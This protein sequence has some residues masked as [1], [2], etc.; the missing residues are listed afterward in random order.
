M[1]SAGGALALPKCKGTNSSAWTNCYGTYNGPKFSYEGEY[2][3]G[4]AHGKGI[5]IWESGEKYVGDF[6]NDDRNG[7]GTFTWPDGQ[8][9]V[10]EYKNEKTNGQGIRTW[11][12]GDKYVGQEQN[13]RKNGQGIF[14]YANGK[15]DEGIWKD[16]KFQYAQKTS[17]SSESSLLQLNFT[18]LSQSQ[19]KQVQSILSNLGF[20]NSSIDGLYG[21]GTEAALI[22]YNKQKLNG[23]KLTLKTNVEKL[24]EVLKNE[25]SSQNDQKPAAVKAR[26]TCRA[27][28]PNCSTDEVCYLATSRTK[29]YGTTIWEP[30]EYWSSHVREAKKRGLTCGVDPNVSSNWSDKNICYNATRKVGSGAAWDAKSPNYVAEAKKRGLTCGV[31]EEP[32]LATTPAVVA[33]KT[34]EASTC[35]ADPKMCPVP[36]LCQKAVSFATGSPMW[37]TDAKYSAHIGYAK[38]IGISC[39]TPA[40]VAT[41]TQ[42]AKPVEAPKPINVAQYPNRKALVIGNA[43]YLNQTPLKNPINDARAVAA[44][45]EEVGFTVTYKED[46]GRRDFIRTIDR[47]KEDLSGSDISVFYYAGHGIEIDKQNYLI[48]VDAV[49][50]S[51]AVAKYDTILLDDA[52]EAS[53]NTDK[54]AM[55]LIDACRDN[56]FLAAMKGKN[57]SV[58]RGLSII[59]VPS[60]SVNQIISFAAESGKV[61]SDGTGSNGPYAMALIDL[62]GEP[63]LEV[64]K[65]FR[66]LGDRVTELTGGEQTPVTRNRLSGDDIFLVVK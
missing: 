21:K 65:M 30:S 5:N 35:D 16:D 57:R 34:A 59:E 1:F 64:G 25:S 6:K 24:L 13:D 58:G 54:L 10:G 11:A 27:I 36:D 51:M 33:T 31:A 12:N 52:V 41:N 19:R 15:I 53:I 47:F 50:D 4:M 49:L 43:N 60:S 48:P 18:Q 62:L 42:D 39:G 2:K 26:E 9:Y 29:K 3:N 38:S 63:N 32:I 40:A 20:Y 17:Y 14:Y 44:K 55:V 45:L 28:A 61:A 46:L 56:P 23:A 22:S 37:T 66:R 8:K 7:T